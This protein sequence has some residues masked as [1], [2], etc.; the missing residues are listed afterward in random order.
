M[1]DEIAGIVDAPF[2]IDGIRIHKEQWTNEV[3]ARAYCVDNIGSGLAKSLE[4]AASPAVAALFDRL[5]GKANKEG[6]DVSDILDSR[7]WNV[8]V[9]LVAILYPDHKTRIFKNMAATI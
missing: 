3:V 5:G 1:V 2:K 4:F 6:S 7:V 9:F 8:F